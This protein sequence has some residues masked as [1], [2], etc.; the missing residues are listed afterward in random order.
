MK[1]ADG[2]GACALR[3]LYMHGRFQRGHGHVHVG[4]VGRDA[5]VTRA[6]D[7]EGAVATRD[8]RTTRAGLALVAR[9]GGVAEAHAPRPLEEAA[10]RCSPSTE[11]SRRAGA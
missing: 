5:R 7:G 11:L 8:G 10:R 4:W 2:Y 6:E 9:H 1:V 3:A